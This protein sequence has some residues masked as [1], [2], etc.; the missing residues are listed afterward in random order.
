ML[1]ENWEETMTHLTKD[2]PEAY[3]EMVSLITAAEAEGQ[4]SEEAHM[5]AFETKHGKKKAV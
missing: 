4:T 1:L 2:I 5:I 3:E